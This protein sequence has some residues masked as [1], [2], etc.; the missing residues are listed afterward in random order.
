MT[1]RTWSRLRPFPRIVESGIYSQFNQMPDGT[2]PALKKKNIDTGAGLERLASGIKATFHNFET[3]L[4]FPDYRICAKLP[5]L[6]M[7][8]DANTD[9]SS[10]G[11]R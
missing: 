9:V 4:D 5:V 7:G 2:Y 6:N 8:K 11:I 10:R 1:L 3:D